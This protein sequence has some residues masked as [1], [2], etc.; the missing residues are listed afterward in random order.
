MKLQVAV[1]GG[2]YSR[3][4]FNSLF[5]PDWRE[6]FECTYNAF[7]TSLLSLTSAPVPYPR[8]L[9]SFKGKKYTDRFRNFLVRELN[10]S[11]LNDL[12]SLSPDIIMLDFYDDALHGVINIDGRSYITRQPDDMPCNAVSSYIINSLSSKAFISLK[13]HDGYMS[14]W[15]RAADTFI[16]FLR[17]YLPK[18]RVLLNCPLFADKILYPDGRIEEYDPPYVERINKMHR[19]MIDYFAGNY[20]NAVLMELKKEYYTDPDY[21]YGAAWIAHYHK[22]FYEDSY[23]LL[24]ELSRDMKSEKQNCKNNLLTNGSFKYGTLFF[25]YWSRS[26]HIDSENGE[27]IAAIDQTGETKRKWPQV[28]FNDIPLD[29]SGNV[30]YTVSFDVRVSSGVPL[31]DNLIFAVRTFEK[32]GFT[33]RKDCIEETDIYWD[34]KTCDKFV[35]Y[36]LTFKPKGNFM[37]PGLLCAQNGRISWKNVRLYRSGFEPDASEAAENITEELLIKDRRLADVNYLRL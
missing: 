3:D 4:L 24:K 28:W 9:L 5:I 6:D 13:D 15:R 30:E 21:P 20:E 2:C 23:K 17:K 35:P 14:V 1:I 26:F 12:L 19:E 34:G 10:K 18:T 8:A 7:Q 36:S 31:E 32:E 27:N 22:N 37:S 33:S 16:S 25:K 11:F 29:G